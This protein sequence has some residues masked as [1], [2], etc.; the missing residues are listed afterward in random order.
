[1]ARPRQFD[2][3]EVRDR[4]ADVFV[5]H[6]FRGTSVAMLSEAAGVGKQGLYNA[7]GDKQALYLQAL[8]LTVGRMSAAREAM[9][10]CASG[11]AAIEAFFL[12]VVQVCAHPDP[13]VNTCIVSAGLLEGIAEAPVNDKLCE[14]WA[15][16]QELLM[17][18]VRRGQE[19]GT[20]RGDVEAV[21]WGRLLMTLMSGLRVTA[22]ALRDEAL[23]RKTT[24][25]MLQILWKEP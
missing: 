19:D 7:F 9:A 8:D 21:E 17:A 1:M 25:L 13:A 2:E 23:L 11:R 14:K 18:A 4:I 15:W 12:I 24:Q 10:S 6:G 5:A 3:Q 20:V 22:R 16:T